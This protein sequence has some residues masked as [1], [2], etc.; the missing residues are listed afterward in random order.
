MKPI[1]LTKHATDKLA[2]R[3]GTEEE[4]LEAVETA[5]W[6]PAPDGKVQCA[7]D[8]NYEDYWKERWFATKKVRPI[9]VELESAI[10]VV[11]VIVYYF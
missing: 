2:E 9:F 6:E 8:F 3:G 5:S 1:H 4:V 10:V 11:T 7:K